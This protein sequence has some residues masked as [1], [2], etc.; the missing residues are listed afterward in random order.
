MMNRIL[1]LLLAAACCAARAGDDITWTT[2]RSPDGATELA[3]GMRAGWPV[4]KVARHGA[5]VLEPSALMLELAA[6]FAGGFSVESVTPVVTNATWKPLYGERTVYPESYRGLLLKLAEQGPRARRLAIEA[7]VY[8]EGMA[9]R[10]VFPA[11]AWKLKR[12]LTE[13]RF[14]A[15]SKAFPIYWTEET[16]AQP[17]VALAEVK[18]GA[19]TPLTIQLPAGF[20]SVLEA[21]CANYARLHLGKTADGALVSLL[22]GAVESA[23]PFTSPWRVILLGDNEGQLIEHEILIPTLNPPCAIA[24]TS[25]IAPG[26][27][28]SNEGSA[29]LV[30]RDLKRIIDFAGTN[31]FKYLQL[32]WGWYGTE[33]KW[34]DADRDTFRK[35][36]PRYATRTD[37]IANTEADPFKVAQGPVPYRCDWKSVTTVDLDLPDLIRHGREHGMGL[38]LYVE[39]AHTLR[40]VDMDKLFGTYEA[41]GVAGLKPGFVRV[42]SQENTQWIR[43]MIAT[44]A[45]HRLWLCIHDGHLPDGSERTYPNLFI[46]EG[47]GGQE[48]SHPAIHDV[49]LPF[50]RCLAGPFDY[51]P[52]LYAKGKTHAHMLAFLVAYYGPAQ[53]IRGGYHAW[54]GGGDQGKG[55]AELE[56]VKRVPAVWDDTKVL[57]AKIAQRVVVARRS[58]GT[59]FIGGMTGAEAQTPEVKLDFLKPGSSYTATIFSDDAAAAS[60]GWCPA[61]RE[62]KRV[63]AADKLALPMEKAGGCVV[64]LDPA[65]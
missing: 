57:D 60:G 52:L 59:W 2:T 18:A 25:W 3:L 53:T 29:P 56:F 12:E 1:L 38:C 63:T 43:R 39:A 42:G 13:F 5:T 65:P 9:L 47:G 49:T 22:T 27:T 23:E 16:F 30:G 28:I 10:Y 6:P 21:D 24:D 17:P 48:G 37:W 15:G 26:K 36:M 35:T 31:G 32:D 41:W 4:Y 58:G 46:C 14:V 44:A 61:K 64:I 19:H 8:N 51:T 11:G 62:T 34:T 54:T 50:T 55:G 45:Q 33:W 20:A 7:R 40:A